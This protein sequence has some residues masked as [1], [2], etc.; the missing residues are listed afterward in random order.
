MWE[1]TNRILKTRRRP[2]AR[3]LLS[4]YNDLISQSISFSDH[5]LSFAASGDN[6]AET[7][8][9]A[10]MQ[11]I[12]ISRIRNS[13]LN[14]QLREYAFCPQTWQE[15]ENCFAKYVR[16][17]AVFLKF[18]GYSCNREC[19]RA[20][21]SRDDIRM[22]RNGFPPENYN[23]HIKIPFDFGGGLDFENFCLV[24]IRPVHNLIH[25]LIDIQIENDFLRTHKKVFIPWF[26]GKIY[27]D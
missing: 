8:S 15:M 12:L 17:R 2:V 27:H 25:R 1:W 7:R 19:R 14:L 13:G 6:N 3:S 20:G 5:N 24:P 21:L 18:L 11:S 23:I 10:D 16:R 9:N 22:L 4:A 26:E